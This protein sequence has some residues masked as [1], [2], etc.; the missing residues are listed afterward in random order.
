MTND[1]HPKPTTTI[2]SLTQETVRVL[3]EGW[4]GGIGPYAT[5]GTMEGNGVG[6]LRLY[7]T[8]DEGLCLGWHAYEPYPVPVELPGEPQGAEEVRAAAETIARLVHD[9]YGP[10]LPGAEDTF[11][12]LAIARRAAKLIGHGWHA[13]FYSAAPEG[14]AALVVPPE[15]E[16]TRFELP[17]IFLNRDSDELSLCGL[18][19]ELPLGRLRP[20]ALDEHASAAARLIPDLLQPS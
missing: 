11:P 4:T 1:S 12:A 18:Q 14:T 6:K 17:S 5:Y 10:P 8:E 7:V 16:G 20:N 9:T 2:T 19:Q 13:E 15:R 3:G